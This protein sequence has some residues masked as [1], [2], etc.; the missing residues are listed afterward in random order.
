MAILDTIKTSL[1]ISHTSLDSDIT[2][3]INAAKAE[4][5][6]AG[7]LSTAIVDT[8]A[9]ILSAI[10]AYCKYNYESD[11]VRKEAFW[12]SWELQLDNLRKSTGYSAFIAA[13]DEE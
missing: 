7:V 10:K 11:P 3:D 4:L 6:R 12:K 5:E 8:D 1:R 13:Q 2:A 9:L